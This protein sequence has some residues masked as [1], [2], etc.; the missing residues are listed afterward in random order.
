MDGNGDEEQWVV[1]CTKCSQLFRPSNPQASYNTHSTPTNRSFCK[2]L[3]AEE[4]KKEH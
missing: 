3:L 2:G 4:K 1:A